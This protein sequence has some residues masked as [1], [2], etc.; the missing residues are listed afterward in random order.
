MTKQAQL[1]V[2]P[3][4]LV[5][6]RLPQMV[7]ISDPVSQNATC[8]ENGF[9]H[10]PVTR[11]WFLDFASAA[12]IMILFQQGTSFPKPKPSKDSREPHR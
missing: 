1:P 3:A 12:D 9:Q 6:F 2:G 11:C 4:K 10:V 5:P 8:L 7:Q